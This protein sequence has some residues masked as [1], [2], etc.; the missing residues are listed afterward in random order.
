MTHPSGIQAQDEA[1]SGEEIRMMAG[2][3]KRRYLDSAA[4]VARHFAQEHKIIGDSSRAETWRRVALC[5]E[6][7]GIIPT[8]S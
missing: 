2:I 4:D 1:M 5:V 7:P 8:L 6:N 3:L